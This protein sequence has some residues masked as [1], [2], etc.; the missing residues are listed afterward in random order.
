L[1][2]SYTTVSWWD[3]KSIQWIER[4]NSERFINIERTLFGWR[5]PRIM[6][7]EYHKTE[8]DISA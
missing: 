3:K 8:D 5:W 1:W 6:I 7:G 2:K 4:L